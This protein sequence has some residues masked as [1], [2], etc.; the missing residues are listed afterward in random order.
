MSDT[1]KVACCSGDRP[2]DNCQC[3][4]KCIT[5]SGTKEVSSA[6]GPPCKCTC[7]CAH[8]EKCVCVYELK[9]PSGAACKCTCVCD[10]SSKNK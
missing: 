4:R 6:S 8:H 9:C 1:C 3:S 10:C 2:D 7:K 5:V